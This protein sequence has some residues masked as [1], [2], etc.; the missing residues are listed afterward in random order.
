M[1]YKIRF[2][3]AHNTEV[4]IASFLYAG[5]ITAIVVNP[6]ERKLANGT[7]VQTNENQ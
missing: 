6:P 2:G 7:S 4:R 3:P 5:F 1:V